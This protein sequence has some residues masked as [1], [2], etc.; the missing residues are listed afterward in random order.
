MND[1]K[2]SGCCWIKGRDGQIFVECIHKGCP[3]H[4]LQQLQLKLKEERKSPKLEECFS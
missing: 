2:C 3:G 1:L 4:R